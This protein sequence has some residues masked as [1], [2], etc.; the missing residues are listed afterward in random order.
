MSF[1]LSKAEDSDVRPNKQLKSV[2]LDTNYYRN[3]TENGLDDDKNT[4]P[5]LMATL[6]T[7]VDSIAD[8]HVNQVI[9]KTKRTKKVKGKNK[10]STNDNTPET[11]GNSKRAPPKKPDMG[12]PS[13]RKLKHLPKDTSP[14]LSNFPF[15]MDEQDSVFAQGKTAGSVAGKYVEPIQE[16]ASPNA[17][18]AGGQFKNTNTIEVC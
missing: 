8:N 16:S 11:D 10:T 4:L 12:S 6:N 1:R 14:E 3:I 17:A 15:F 7:Y 2:S 9:Q 5:P 13:P 18:R